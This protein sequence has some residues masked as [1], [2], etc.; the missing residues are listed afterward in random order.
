MTL[1]LRS[2]AIAGL[3]AVAVVASSTGRA[4][5]Q[6]GKRFGTVGMIKPNITQGLIEELIPFLPAGTGYVPVYLDFANGTRDEFASAM[7]AYERNIALLADQKCDLIA[8]EGAP[9]FMIQGPQREAEI[10]SGWEKKYRVPIFTSSQNQV[11]ALR[12]LRVKRFVGAT[13]LSADQNRLFAKYFTDVGFTVLSMDG[14]DVPFNKVQ[15]VPGAEIAAYIRKNVAKQAGVEGIYMLGS[16]WHTLD[17]IAPLERELGIPVVH[18]VIA[19]AWEIQ[20]RLRLRA[21]M[22]GYGRLMSE[23]PV[24]AI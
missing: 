18:P 3:A 20:R 12:A 1:F 4:Q 21:P 7:P 2:D 22:A 16:G 17:I 14:F 6:S 15:D 11:N 5:A 23:L 19:R 10:V 8:A 9:P 24:L 13:Y